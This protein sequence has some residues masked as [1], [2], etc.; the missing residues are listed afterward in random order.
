MVELDAYRSR[1]LPPGEVHKSEDGLCWW[2]ADE[3]H[4]VTVGKPRVRKKNAT[5]ST[6]RGEQG[7]EFFTAA[8]EAHACGAQVLLGDRNFEEILRRQAHAKKADEKQAAKSSEKRRRAGLDMEKLEGLIARRSA[9]G[10]EVPVTRE[11]MRKWS[12]TMKRLRPNEHVANVTERDEV[13][14]RNL[15]GLK[16]CRIT[17]AVVGFG[18]LDGIESQWLGGSG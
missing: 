8:V 10:Q 7:V 15:M 14:S 5:P 18:H 16:N 9:L 11:I 3:K 2:K 17:V 13:M 12:A 4:A 6:E 1:L